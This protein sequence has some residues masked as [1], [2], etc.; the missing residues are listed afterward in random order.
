MKKI[1][2]KSIMSVSMLIM[3]FLI[4]SIKESSY[5][6]QLQYINKSSTRFINI[7]PYVIDGTPDN[8]MFY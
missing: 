6:S 1:L 5:T 7:I 2:Y 3:T 4:C 8:T